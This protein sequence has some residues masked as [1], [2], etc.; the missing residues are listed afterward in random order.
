MPLIRFVLVRDKYGPRNSTETVIPLGKEKYDEGHGKKGQQ[1][2]DE[3]RQ[4]AASGCEEGRGQA[5]E[6]S[7][8]QI[9]KVGP[10]RSRFSLDWNLL[11]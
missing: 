8:W 1:K 9:S 6:A 4:G 3:E 10:R 2:P 5:Q 7:D 11:V